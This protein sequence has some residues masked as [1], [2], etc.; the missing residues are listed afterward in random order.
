MEDA[1]KPRII[2]IEEHYL[3][4]NIGVN[5]ESADAL[6]PPPLRERLEDLGALRLKEMDDAGIDVQ[7]L[8]HAGPA[9]QRINAEAAVK[10]SRL[11]NDRQAAYKCKH[12]VAG[13]VSAPGS[14][15]NQAP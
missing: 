12:V 15:K 7:V 11:A 5:F 13:A 10:V 1:T 4:R 14:R 8:S 3:D 9:T 2:A 6:V